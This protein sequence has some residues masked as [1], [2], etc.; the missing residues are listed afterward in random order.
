MTEGLAPGWY[1]HQGHDDALRYWD[2]EQWTDSYKP[3]EPSSNSGPGVSS[4]P[5]AADTESLA[6]IGVFAAVLFPI[7]G[8]IIGFMVA[9]RG[10]PVVGV[11]LAAA[12]VVAATVWGIILFGD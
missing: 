7:A 1:P 12:S 11:G 8:F 5:S 3:K 10:R 9:G 4:G 6:A 2:G